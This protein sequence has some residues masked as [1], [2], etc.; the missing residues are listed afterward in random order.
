MKVIE[1]SKDYQEYELPHGWKKIGKRKKSIWKFYVVSPKGNK[2][3]SNIELEEYLNSN[4][5]IK[6][7]RTLMNIDSTDESTSP[8]KKRPKEIWITSENEDF[9]NS[10]EK[11]CNSLKKELT[12]E[13]ERGKDLKED[14]KSTK[15]N[16]EE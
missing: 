11:E 13:T 14:A 7:D 10:K 3:R 12:P 6:C 9:V 1:Q 4:P 2:F 5:V 16:A 8:K 15:P